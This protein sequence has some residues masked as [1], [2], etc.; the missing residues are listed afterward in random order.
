MTLTPEQLVAN[1][2]GAQQIK[3]ITLEAKIADLESQL[4]QAGATI[5]I[6]NERKPAAGHFI[7]DP[8]DEGDAGW[9]QPRN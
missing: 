6:M 9:P 2:I 1:H 4:A 5:R 3:I 7:A 8:A